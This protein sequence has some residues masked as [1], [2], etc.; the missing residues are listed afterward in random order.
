MLC[1]RN[2]KK[3]IL[4]VKEILLVFLEYWMMNEFQRQTIPDVNYRV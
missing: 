2:T 1:C 4:L 3:K